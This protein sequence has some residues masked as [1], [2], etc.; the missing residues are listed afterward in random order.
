LSVANLCFGHGLL[1]ALSESFLYFPES[2]QLTVWRVNSATDI[3][4]LVDLPVAG[5]E[6]YNRTTN[7]AVDERYIAVFLE[8][9]QSTETFFFSTESWTLMEWS[10][11]LTDVDGRILLYRRGL[12]I[13]QKDNCIR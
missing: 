1:V 6:N 11:T 12:L 10:P 13:T 5:D 4:H 9:W 7:V 8:T 2:R 3:E